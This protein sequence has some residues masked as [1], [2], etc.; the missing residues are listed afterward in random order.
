MELI[1]KFSVIL[2]ICVG[3]AALIMVG[4]YIVDPNI[5]SNFLFKV[6]CSFRLVIKYST[7]LMLF[8]VLLSG[9]WM[10]SYVWSH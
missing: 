5:N 2:A 8:L 4:I 3:M 1:S 6:L 10:I 9:V 7:M